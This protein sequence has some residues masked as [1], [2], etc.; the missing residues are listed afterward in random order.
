[1]FTL[2]GPS[3]NT[4]DTF[5]EKIKLVNMKNLIHISLWKAISTSTFPFGKFAIKA[6]EVVYGILKHGYK[7]FFILS[8]QTLNSPTII[9]LFKNYEFAGE[10]ITETLRAG[11]MKESLTKPKVVNPLSVSTKGKDLDLRYENCYFY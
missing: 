9:R 11:T 5:R 10:S 1:M 4:T 8:F 2:I 6:N 3:L 7:P